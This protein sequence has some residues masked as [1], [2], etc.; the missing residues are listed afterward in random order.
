[1]TKKSFIPTRTN[2]H[3]RHPDFFDATL[4]YDT[5][6]ARLQS[7]GHD[8]IR[9]SLYWDSGEDKDQYNYLVNRQPHAGIITM[10]LDGYHNLEDVDSWL[11]GVGK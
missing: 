4:S 8:F 2:I 1:M 6:R 7:I 5:V 9:E 3:D 10:N 11:R